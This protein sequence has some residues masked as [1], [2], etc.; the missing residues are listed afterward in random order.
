MNHI[1]IPAIRTAPVHPRL[2]L[3]V[4]GISAALLQWA[5]LS[6]HA[7]SAV[8]VDMANGNVLNPPGRS[9]VPRPLSSDG[10]DTVRRSPS[11]QLYGIPY[12]LTDEVTTTEDGWEYTGGVEAGYLG[13]DTST[14][15]AL[16]R[17]YK[18]L[19]NGPYLNYFEVEANDSKTARYMSALGGGTGQSDQFY[20]FQYG[21]YNDWKV[22]LFYSETLHVFTDT[23]KSLYNGTGSGNLT[24]PVGLKPMGGATPITSNNPTIG[25]GGCTPA[26]PCW[27]YTGADGITKIY[28]NATAA[29]GINWTA[30]AT[31]TADIPGA[32]V[33]V[34]SIAGNINTY[35]NANGV[36]ANT[37]LSLVRQ[38]AGASGEIK[39]TD[40]WKGYASYTQEQRKGARPF[41]MNENNYTAEIPEPID[42]VSH[43]FLTGISYADSLTQANLRASASVFHNNINTLTV[44]QPWLA[45]ATGVGAAQTT[46][47]DLYPDNQAFNLKGEFARSLPDFYRGRFT[48][49]AAFGSSTQD[50]K[51]LMPVSAAESAQIRAGMGSSIVQGINNPG[52]A[53]NTLD[54]ANWDG[55]NGLPL[56]QSSGK[57]RIDTQLLNAT[58]SVKPSD[59]LTVKGDLRQYATMNQGGYTAYNPLTAQFGR[60]F[61]NSTSFDLVVGNGGNLGAIGQPCYV[62]PGYPPPTVSGCLFNGNA[63]VTGQSTNNPANIPVRSPA[64]NTTQTNYVLTGDYDLGKS[65]SVNGSLER[66]DFHRTFREREN[67]WEDKVKL[68]YVNR[69]YEQATLRM[70][71]EDG[72]RRGSEYEFWPIDDFGTRLPGLDW[73][74]IVSKY[75]V[76]TTGNGWTGVNKNPVPTAPATANSLAGYLARYAYESRKYDQ[77]DRD[78]QIFNARLNILATDDIDLGVSLQ[79]KDITYPN[80][81]YGLG[82]DRLSSVNLEASYQPSID[83]Q[84][85]GYYSTQEGSKS[86]KANAGTN[87][88][89][90]NNACSFASGANL[91][92]AQAITQCAQQ[93]WLAAAAWNMDSLDKSDLIGLGF[94]TTL[95]GNL[96]LGVDY[97]YSSS[98]SSVTYGYGAN[99]LT[100]AQ[101]TAAQANTFSDMTLIQ[102]TLTLNL[103]IPIQK[104]SS[105]RVMYRHESGS[106]KDWHYTGMPLGASAAEGNATLMLD[107]GP[108]DYHTNVIGVMFQ[109]LL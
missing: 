79:N 57:Q 98:T 67:T 109:F 22:K 92:T 94:Q 90:A 17:K 49:V 47:F 45:A 8:G 106:V 43:D 91:T 101:I 93:V 104:K 41:G 19:E 55:T 80:S 76:N 4:L 88:A 77:A 73:N 10:M 16:Y 36:E 59:D 11:G 28:S 23:Y 64:R 97:T 26:A 32:P 72:R 103:L 53:T 2:K 20:G 27:K 61:R 74:T 81:G 82:K 63:G 18:D 105:A 66:E 95:G 50:D 24:L 100:A 48:A 107:A 1:T 83:K 51:L 56:S 78:Q 12:D 69:G 25:T 70:S 37:E 6:V 62:E 89:G 84:F 42:Y 44:D 29:A 7:D 96:R 86:M 46:T 60:G 30:N 87:A 21:R 54:L 58:L 13:G 99:V 33:S 31:K 68:G 71:Y 35:L 40:N 34:N 52:Y 38:K 65:S 102:N 75:L 39:F 3:L 5:A 14:K 108:Q 9:A 85:Y 15:N